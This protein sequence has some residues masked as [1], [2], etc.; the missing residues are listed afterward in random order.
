[1]KSGVEKSQ[2]L[3][4]AK[5]YMA[6]GDAKRTA[7][8]KAGLSLST[9]NKWLDDD[10]NGAQAPAQGR[11]AVIEMSV[12]EVNRLRYWRLTK[13]GSLPLAVRA[14]VADPVCRPETRATLE[15]ILTRYSDRRQRCEFPPSLRRLAHIT[16]EEMAQFRSK[17]RVQD[18]ELV[19]SRG[20]TFIDVDGQ[21]CPLVPNSLWESDDMS[22][23]QPFRW[24][25]PTT[26]KEFVGRQTLCTIDVYS[27]LWLA[28]QPIG[29]DR[30]A[31]RVEDIADH[32]EMLVEEKGL[33]YCWRLERGSWES[34]FVHGIELENGRRW[35][36][37]DELFHVIHTWK[38]RAKGT[39]EGGFR[40]VQAIMSHQ[41][42]DIGRV[43]GEYDFAAREL[44]RAQH[45]QAD[46]LERFWTIDEAANG[47]AAA[48]EQDNATLKNRRAHLVGS[49]GLLVRANDLYKPEIVR[50][51]PASERWRFCPVKRIATI[52]KGKVVIRDKYYTKPFEFVVNDGSW[53]GLLENGTPVLIA[54]HPGRPHEGCHVFN[55]LPR[56]D[57]RNRQRWHF[58][59]LITVALPL[60]ESP[61]FTLS[62]TFSEQQKTANAAMR[63]EYRGI[64]PAGQHPGLKTST[65]RDNLGNMLHIQ[66]GQSAPRAETAR[67]FASNVQFPGVAAEPPA[68]AK[69][70]RTRKLD[71]EALRAAAEE[72]LFGTSNL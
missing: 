24:T 5:S 67:G 32:M 36:G 46:A 31:Y 14:L 8:T 35:G 51:L 47:L 60:V 12:E 3:A 22:L 44:R 20:L 4:L 7:A 68:A 45:G 25:E 56:G 70:R 2:K 26:G 55:F 57:V 72:K 33:P 64:V 53:N 59:A 19:I 65:A 29:R 52:Q 42:M 71:A 27:H 48:M 6:Q 21:E 37:V 28:G 50:P 15:G 17:K 39:I 40:F 49:G 54:F 11:K 10:G 1:M 61:Q 23:N 43:R 58:G 63:R 38:S 16:P 9:L 62:G 30:D 13:D 34:N 41:S 69:P 18:Y 66:T